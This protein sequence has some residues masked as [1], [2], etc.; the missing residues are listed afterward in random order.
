[1]IDYTQPRFTDYRYL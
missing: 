1:M